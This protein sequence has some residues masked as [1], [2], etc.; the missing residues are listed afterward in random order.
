MIER[1]SPPPAAVW[2][3]GKHLFL[4]GWPRNERKEKGKMRNEV[5]T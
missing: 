3:A 4:G 1:T 2:V 5:G